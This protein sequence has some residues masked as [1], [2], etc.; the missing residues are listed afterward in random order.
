[1][2]QKKQYPYEAHFPLVGGKKD[3]LCAEHERDLL[4]LIRMYVRQRS[5]DCT[6]EERA[7]LLLALETGRWPIIAEKYEAANPHLPPPYL[8][9]K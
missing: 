7:Q 3:V 4:E 6:P 9:I 5:N 2:D 8:R 1:M